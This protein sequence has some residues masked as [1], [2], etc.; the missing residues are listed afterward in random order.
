MTIA[1]IVSEKGYVYGKDFLSDVLPYDRELDGLLGKCEIVSDNEGFAELS[2]KSD[3]LYIVKVHRENV[4]G[5]LYFPFQLGWWE[6]GR[7]M[8]WSE[9]YAGFNYSLIHYEKK[10]GDL[11]ASVVISSCN[12]PEW[13]KKVLEGYRVQD[14]DA[15]FELIIADD[16][17]DKK[18]FDM[19]AGVVPQLPFRVKHVW[20][21]DRGFRKCEILNR[22]ILAANSNY[23]IFSD[24]DCIP[25]KD[26][27]SV[28][29]KEREKGRFLSGGYY[30]LSAGLSAKISRDD[31]DSGRCFDA[32]WLVAEGMP[33]NFKLNKFTATGIKRRLLNTFTPA[34]AS[35][36]GHGA[37]G[38]LSDI[39]F[40]NGFDER[41]Q[42]GGQDREF[43]ERLENKGVYGKQ[44]RYSTVVLHLDH[45]R[46]YKT[47]ESINKNK[48][49]RQMTRKNKTKWTPF[50]IVKAEL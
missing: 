15:G 30:K 38:W 33:K 32:R 35:W 7:K 16:G 44:I 24:G 6:E 31:I 34:N 25:R 50:G 5:D 10:S 43:G 22:A 17:S 1:A 39:L 3:E 12:H 40:V 48:M 2:A 42:Y 36:N 37:S 19:L 27:V 46:G 21:E 4:E 13:L 11:S 45:A 49:I 28:H 23:L 18:T 20:Q 9:S 14:C 41:M 29:L 8:V 47:S 26:L